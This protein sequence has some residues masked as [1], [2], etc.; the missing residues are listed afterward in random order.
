MT[1]RNVGPADLLI[2]GA[3]VFGAWTAYL[4]RQAGMSVVL[5]DAY[6]AG[7]GRASSGGETRVIRC[8]Y[9]PDAL[10]TRWA[11]RSLTEWR[12]LQARTGARVFHPTGVLTVGHAGDAQT[13][14]TWDTLRAHDVAAERLSAA[15][16]KTRFA[17][18][19]FDDDAWGI[20]EPESGVLR[21]RY[22]VDL[23]VRECRR[24]G[25]RFHLARVDAP[26][27]TGRL[28]AVVTSTGIRLQAAQFVFAC[29]PWLPA[30]LPTV[31]G[32][33]IQPTRQEVFFFGAPA[34][35]DRFGPAALPAWIDFSGGVY[36]L[37]DLDGRGVK[38]AFDRHG[39]PFDPDTGDRLVSIDRVRDMRAVLGARLPALRSAPLLETRVCQ[40]ENTWNGDFL[41][42]RDPRF[43]NV[44]IAGGGS[45]HGFKHG[46]AVA[47]Y[48]LGLMQGRQQVEPRFTLATKRTTRERSVY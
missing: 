29:G 8:G 37:P 26:L 17:Q 2:A 4:A 41:I 39:P 33:R 30:L 1:M 14:A 10:Y 15:A 31:I 12:A 3:G 5:V 38:L 16:L 36:G 34:G 43:D 47:E 40:Y 20:I 23:I 13:E 21:A 35:D 22:A 18:L 11:Q 48:L 32:E 9:G 19:S 25:A 6:G 45:G 27:G 42:D 24:L 28:D 44:W 7:H 46:P